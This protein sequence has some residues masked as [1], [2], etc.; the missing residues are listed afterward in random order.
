MN[1]KIKLFQNSRFLYLGKTF[2]VLNCRI[3]DHKAMIFTDRQTFVKY[4]TELDTFLT[5]VEF[6]EES[7]SIAKIVDSEKETARTEAISEIKSKGEVIVPNV[8]HA[9]IMNANNRAMRISEKL[10]DVFNSISEGTADETLIKKADAM[11]RL[12]NAIV[13]NELTRFKYLNLK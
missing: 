1:E 5:E 12:S 10:E 11:V 9:E 8:Y 2:K 7:S 13:S 6:I 4:E 3:Q